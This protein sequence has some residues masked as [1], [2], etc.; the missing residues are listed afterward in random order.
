MLF[1]GGVKTWSMVNALRELGVDPGCRYPEL[2]SGRF[3]TGMKALVP[4]AFVVEDTSTAGLLG[5]MKKDA[6]SDRG[7]RQGQVSG[8]KDQDP[9]P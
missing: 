9:V 5:V 4:G 6:G 3:N 8:L 1:T 2:H 7:R